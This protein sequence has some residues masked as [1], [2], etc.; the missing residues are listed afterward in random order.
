MAKLRRYKEKRYRFGSAKAR[1]KGLNV[2]VESSSRP[3][4]LDGSSLGQGGE[5]VEVEVRGKKLMF[6]GFLFQ[7]SLARANKGFAPIERRS[8]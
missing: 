6:R 4:G 7:K 1:V 5:R 2:R 8:D 3:P